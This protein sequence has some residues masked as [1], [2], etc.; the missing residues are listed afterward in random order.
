MAKAYHLLCV[1]YSEEYMRDIL[2]VLTFIALI[3]VSWTR[4]AVQERLENYRPVVE[5]IIATQGLATGEESTTS[6]ALHSTTTD[7]KA[8]SK[9]PAKTTVV[10]AK[11]TAVQIKLEENAPSSPRVGTTS[12][13]TITVAGN[14][15]LSEQTSS[16]ERALEQ[17]IHTR[18]NAA[19]AQYGLEPVSWNSELATIARAHSADMRVRQYFNHEDPDGCGITCRAD[20]ISYAWRAI[21]E[22]IY[23]TEGYALDAPE[24]GAM[25]VS[26]WMNSAG[27]RA[28]ILSETFSEEAIGVS[29]AGESAY[30]TEVLAR[31]LE[32]L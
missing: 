3:V 5:R 6:I 7:T 25:I 10:V 18:V 32:T 26:G 31:P 8:A 1:V 12:S 28:N 30:I 23:M 20:T 15:A 4:P 24:L 22:N 2:F 16:F 19:R 13:G 17:E 9:T 11:K 27:H 29:A 14:A 21:G